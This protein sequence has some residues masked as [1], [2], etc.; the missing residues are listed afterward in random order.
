MIFDLRLQFVH[1]AHYNYNLILNYDFQEHA[2]KV[3]YYT[4]TLSIEASPMGLWDS[5]NHFTIF[6]QPPYSFAACL[7]SSRLHVRMNY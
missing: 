5:L 2:S 1:D 4:V 3:V 7:A 6:T